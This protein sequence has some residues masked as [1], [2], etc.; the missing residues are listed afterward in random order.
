LNLG[1]DVVRLGYGDLVRGNAHVSHVFLY[2]ETKSFDAILSPATAHDATPWP[3]AGL[4]ASAPALPSASSRGA[5]TAFAAGR[6]RGPPSCAGSQCSAV[7]TER[8]TAMVAP[9]WA[10]TRN[11][12]APRSPHRLGT[13]ACGYEAACGCAYLDHVLAQHDHGIASGHPR[14]AAGG[15]KLADTAANG[16]SRA[17]PSTACQRELDHTG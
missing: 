17:A 11:G 3:T 14:A 5:S 15:A 7:P 6:R 4:R 12:R 1:G 10:T 13:R 8:N 2:S 16:I 9:S